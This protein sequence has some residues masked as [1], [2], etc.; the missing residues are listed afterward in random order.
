MAPEEANTVESPASETMSKTGERTLLAIV[1]VV[2]STIC[3]AGGDI[4]AKFMRETAP[5]PLAVWLRYFVYLVL[6]IPY[7][8]WR[9]G[10]SVFLPRSL[11][12]QLGRGLGAVGSTT[13]FI[14]GLGY[15]DVPTGTAIH[16]I[17]PIIV[18]ALSVIFLGEVV[19]IRRWIAALF[20]FTGVLL[21][22][23]PGT[24][25]FQLA[26]LFPICSATSWAFSALFTRMNQKDSFETTFLWTGILGVAVATLIAL[27]DLRLPVGREWISGLG[28]SLSFTMAQ[29][30]MIAAF[31]MAPLSILAPITYA[32]LISA[33]VLSYLFFDTVP[34]TTT[35]LGAALI[36]GAGLYSS[37]RE[38]IK[39]RPPTAIQPGS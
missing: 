15:L 1:L 34:D 8:T 18:M 30:L 21:I 37:H 38:R 29:F 28:G 20:G 23:R 12:L 3:F 2:F 7:A 16:F 31:R 9:R 32:Q 36:A 27:P 13:F 11:P 5:G 26:A 19:G 14:A 17:S 6:A 39:N 24:D 10:P 35:F 4:G 25:A 33:G 22:V